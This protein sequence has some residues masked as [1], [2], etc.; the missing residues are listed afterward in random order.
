MKV[1][2][3]DGHRSATRQGVI[4]IFTDQVEIGQGF[5][6]SEIT[7]LNG[8]HVDQERSFNKATPQLPHPSPVSKGIGDQGIGGDS[9]D[10]VVEVTDL[11][12]RQGHRLTISVCAKLFP[13]CT[14][15]VD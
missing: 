3:A 10:G 9:G 1:S 7:K 11:D 8:A 5:K 13:F 12:R 6:H 2:P 15:L 14:E 4:D